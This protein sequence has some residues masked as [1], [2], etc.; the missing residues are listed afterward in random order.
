MAAVG[1]GFSQNKVMTLL[2]AC[3]LLACLI[4]SIKAQAGDAEFPS[5]RPGYDPVLEAGK[6]Q[7]TI[8]WAS[9]KAGVFLRVGDHIIFFE[10]IGDGHL[11]SSLTSNLFY[12]GVLPAVGLMGM[13]AFLRMYAGANGGI[14]YALGWVTHKISL[15]GIAWMW[16][17]QANNMYYNGL[18]SGGLYMASKL[19]AGVESRYSSPHRPFSFSTALPAVLLFSRWAVNGYRKRASNQMLDSLDI[20]P[21][22]C[23]REKLFMTLYDREREGFEVRLVRVP[24][25]LRK[26]HKQKVAESCKVWDNLVK[27]MDRNR[28]DQLSLK[29]KVRPVRRGLLQQQLQVDISDYRQRHEKRILIPLDQQYMDEELPWLEQMLIDGETRFGLHD[30]RTVLHPEYI[31]QIS[32]AL[33]CYARLGSHET[34]LECAQGILHAQHEE[35]GSH[36]HDVIYDNI[37]NLAYHALGGDE[38]IVISCSQLAWR[39]EELPIP[40]R[41]VQVGHE[42]TFFYF[43]LPGKKVGHLAWVDS[44]AG[45]ALEMRDSAP[46]VQSSERSSVWQYRISR[47]TSF[48]LNSELNYLA[49]YLPHMI[50]GRAIIPAFE[51][52][53]PPLDGGASLQA[54]DAVDALD[55]L[56]DGM[57]RYAPSWLANAHEI[58]QAGRRINGALWLQVIRNHD[59]KLFL[60][61]CGLR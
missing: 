2:P 29:V 3:L 53:L 28:I 58:Q 57:S 15:T 44:Y 14:P 46:S 42:K 20:N 13:H 26:A 39:P 50:A 1:S 36:V 37:R 33:N 31:S 8:N 19:A 52:F 7:S 17:Q 4:V 23:L 35:R 54:R 6:Q 32:S 48:A 22:P 45:P 40:R 27:V 49:R 59:W 38:W 60:W 9:N 11:K 41:W 43:D 56:Q 47:S 25:N 10:G 18:S 21:P 55:G 34:Y 61:L 12:G 16:L 24:L 30:F 5:E 51:W